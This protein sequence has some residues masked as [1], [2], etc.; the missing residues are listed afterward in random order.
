MMAY[1]YVYVCT[2]MGCEDE[3]NK[4]CGYGYSCPFCGEGR[5]MLDE[6]R[7]DELNAARAGEKGEK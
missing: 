3:Q 1:I 2:A 4:F 5:M 6:G 7:T